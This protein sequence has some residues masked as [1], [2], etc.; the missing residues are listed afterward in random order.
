MTKGQLIERIS[1]LENC[2]TNQA[3]IAVNTIFHAMREALEDNQRVEIR[4]FGTFEVRDYQAYTGRNPK[5][6]DRVSVPPKRAPFFKAG[7]TLKQ[8][9]NEG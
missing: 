2:T 3:E 6:G 7:K 1:Q 8:K 4:G 5:T 9:L